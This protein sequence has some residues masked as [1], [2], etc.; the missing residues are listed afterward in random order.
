MPRTP[1]KLRCGA[2]DDISAGPSARARCRAGPTEAGFFASKA[3]RS[4]GKNWDFSRRVS[5]GREGARAA[6]DRLHGSTISA[7]RSSYRASH[8]RKWSF[9]YGNAG[10]QAII[11]R[12]VF[13][14]RRNSAS[15]AWRIRSRSDA[16]ASAPSTIFD[17]VVPGHLRQPA[18]D[19]ETASA[20]TRKDAG[21]LLEAFRRAHPGAPRYGAPG[22]LVV[23]VHLDYRQLRNM[24]S[25]WY[26][27]Q[28]RARIEY[29]MKAT[30]IIKHGGPAHPGHPRPLRHRGRAPASWVTSTKHIFSARLDMEV[31]GPDNTVCRMR[32]RF[33]P[34]PGPGETPTANAFLRRRK[35]VPRVGN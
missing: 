16:I 15:A 4:P 6:Q 34:P 35:R 29:E 9:P 30:G 11:A 7:A 23:S 5:N 27:H 20:C 28:G 14:Q 24:A 31:D 33:A 13:R 12:N 19:R 22:K 3:A 26:L 8:R 2:L 17:A 18:D 32:P 1:L 21:P 10:A 25:Y